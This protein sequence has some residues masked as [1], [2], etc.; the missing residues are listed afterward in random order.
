M[1]LQELKI[2]ENFDISE[3][4][5]N[6]PELIHLMVEQKMHFD[7]ERYGGDPRLSKYQ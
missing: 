4:S 6:D 5:F 7:R 2:L 1:M 3:M